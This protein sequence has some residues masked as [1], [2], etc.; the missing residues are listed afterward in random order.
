M[1]SLGVSLVL[2]DEFLMLIWL[3]GH[4]SRRFTG[5]KNKLELVL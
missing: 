4:V 5:V 1:N 2:C 3:G